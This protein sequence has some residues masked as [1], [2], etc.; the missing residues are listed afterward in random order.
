LKYDF[1]L[2]E[3]EYMKNDMILSALVNF[4]VPMILIYAFFSLV[5]CLSNGFF[6]AIYSIILFVAAF[7]IYSVRF[8]G[9]KSSLMVS[10]NIISWIGLSIL[11]FYLIVV[12]LLLSGVITSI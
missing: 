2:F 4:L 7:M 1:N 10:I 8:D 6:S 3:E 9:L 11:G 12:F 5:D